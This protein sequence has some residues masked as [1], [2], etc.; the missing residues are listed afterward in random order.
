[1]LIADQDL[2]EQVRLAY[3]ELEL[4]NTLITKV[5]S[6]R[7][8]LK[9]YHLPTAQHSDR[10]G[11]LARSVAEF[12]GINPSV[13]FTGGLLHDIGKLDIPLELLETNSI[14]QAQLKKMEA[15]TLNGYHILKEGLSEEAWIA[16]TH[17]SWQKIPYPIELLPFP[18]GIRR[19]TE[20]FLNNH[21][22]V[23]SLADH[24]DSL[25]RHNDRFK[26]L[27]ATSEIDLMIDLNPDKK[28]LIR[29]LYSKGIFTVREPEMA[30]S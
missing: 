5:D 15:H 6:H 16:L 22:R 18:T 29:K 4:P 24:Y 9:N 1:M 8:K 26:G 13:A 2:D 27:E 10:I 7:E 25:T 12:I 19:I 20:E 3:L 11:I 21:S 23:V 28:R 17:H 30:I 14:T